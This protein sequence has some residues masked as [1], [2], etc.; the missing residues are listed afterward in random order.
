MDETTFIPSVP[1]AGGDAPTAGA[2]PSTVNLGELATAGLCAKGFADDHALAWY[3][4]D[5]TVER[6]TYGELE[7]ASA[8]VASLLVRSGLQPGDRVLVSAPLQPEAVAGI[9]GALRAGAVVAVLPVPRNFEAVHQAV[10]RI[11]PRVVLSIP[12]GKSVFSALKPLLPDLQAVIYINRTRFTLPETAS[13]EASWADAVG[14]GPAEAPPAAAGGRGRALLV[15]SE[16][17]G[18]GV[19][20]AHDLAGA[21]AATGAKVLGMRPRETVLSVL[22][23]G[24]PLFVPYGILAPLLAGST[25]VGLEEPTRFTRYADVAAELQPRSWF[26]SFKALDVLMRTDPNLGRLLKGCHHVT[27]THPADPGFLSMFSISFGAPVRTAWGPPEA[28]A[29]QTYEDQLKFGCAGR[30]VPGAGIRILDGGGREAPAGSPGTVALQ[31]GPA[32]PFLGYWEDD[33]R[34]A[35]RVRDGWLATSRRGRLDHDGALWLE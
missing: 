33:E 23:P 24:E 26:S 5:G 16:S 6:L 32:A 21:L 20:L 12:S 28:G 29:L 13:F 7:Q 27:V 2:D 4:A 8:R 14:T 15:P 30:P 22:V 11:R 31:L 25:L 17:G 9:L 3:A 1:S 19:L 18:P 34:T 10:S 35:E